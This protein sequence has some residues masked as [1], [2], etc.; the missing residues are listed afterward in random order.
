MPSL[1][2]TSASRPSSTRP[3]MM[4][5]RGTPAL[6]AATAWCALESVSGAIRVFCS[7]NDS[8]S[9]TEHLPDELAA[10]DQAVLR[11]DENQ[12]DR[13]QR[14]G[15]RDRHGVGIDP[16]RLAVAVET[17]RRNDRNDALGEQRL[18]QFD[19]HALDLAGEQMVHALNDAHRMGDDDVRAGGAQIIGRKAFKNFV[20]Q[21]VGGGERELE[22]G[23]V[24]DAGAVEIGRH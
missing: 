15:N 22:R 9:A 24:R 6:Q 10:V 16:I 14:I 4:W 20:R 12:F 18:E 23:G 1:E 3:L 13:L 8:R 11:G 17:Q 19:V 2:N 21:P 7:N 5:T